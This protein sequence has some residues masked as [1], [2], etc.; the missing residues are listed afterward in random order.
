MKER[1]NRERH[2]AAFQ[3]HQRENFKYTHFIKTKYISKWKRKTST[4]N[5][6]M[7]KLKVDGKRL[8]KENRGTA[9]K[10]IYLLVGGFLVAVEP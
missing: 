7:H 1:K 9:G 4:K 10:R 3:G 6:I 2:R 5:I 8:Q